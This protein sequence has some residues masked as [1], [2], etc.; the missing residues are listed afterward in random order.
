MHTYHVKFLDQ[1]SNAKVENVKV[2][3]KM[4]GSAYVLMHGRLV[5][6]NV[7]LTVEIPGLACNQ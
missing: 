6:L 4:P 3:W 7:D 5:V 1:R 2:T